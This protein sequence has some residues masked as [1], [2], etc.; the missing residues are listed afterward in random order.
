M[1]QIK[2]TDMYTSLIIKYKKEFKRVWSYLTL[3]TTS[4][5]SASLNA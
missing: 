2:Q 5:E 3:T 1:I 4:S